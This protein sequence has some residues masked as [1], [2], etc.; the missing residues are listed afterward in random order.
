[1][2]KKAAAAESA[3]LADLGAKVRGV[4]VDAMMP[5]DTKIRSKEVQEFNVEKKGVKEPIVRTCIK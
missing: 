4:V 3:T 2:A 5:N 1:M